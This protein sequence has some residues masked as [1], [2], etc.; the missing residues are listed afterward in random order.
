MGMYS[1]AR[2]FP[3]RCDPPE[4]DLLYLQPGSKIRAF[5]LQDCLGKGGMSSVWKATHGETK[6][7]YALKVLHG[8]L[9]DDEVVRQRF[10]E[11][12]LIQARVSHPNV[13][14]V[15]GRIEAHPVHALVMEFVDGP[16]LD[17]TAKERP[18][19]LLL[20]EIK[21][22]STGLLSALNGAHRR[23]I[24]HRDVK[25]NN[26][27]LAQEM[28]S[29]TPKLTDFGIAKF[30]Y[31]RSRT[32]TG[33]PMGTPR[34]MSPEQL[35][36]S[37]SVTLL[38]DIYSFGVTLYYMVTG[39]YPFDRDDLNALMVQIVAGEHDPASSFRTNLPPEI[40]AL[41]ESCMAKSPED[42]PQSCRQVLE[43]ILAI[44][45]NDPDESCTI[46][47]SVTGE[48]SP[49]ARP[50]SAELAAVRDR[51]A[52]I[53][54]PSGA[55]MRVPTGDRLRPSATGGV[56]P[57]SVNIPRK[58]R[59]G[60]LSSVSAPATVTRR[61]PPIPLDAVAD[62]PAWIDPADLSDIDL[63]PDDDLALSFRSSRRR[64]VVIFLLLLLLSAGAASYY[65]Y[66]VEL[67]P[68]DSGEELA[69]T[70]PTDGTTSNDEPLVSEG[71]GATAPEAVTS[72]QEVIG[73]S[74]TT[75]EE[76][77]EANTLRVDGTG[78]PDETITVASATEVGEP[79]SATSPEDTSSRRERDQE[80]ERARQADRETERQRERQRERQ[81]DEGIDREWER[82]LARRREAALNSEPVPLE[83]SLSEQA[84]A[85]LEASRP[86]TNDSSDGEGQNGTPSAT[87]NGNDSGSQAAAEP[88]ELSPL[89]VNSALRSKRS[90]FRNCFDP[91]DSS[92]ITM[93]I[94]IRPDGTVGYASAT[95]AGA[96]PAVVRCLVSVL[97]Q[98]EFDS[99]AGNPMNEQ[100]SFSRAGPR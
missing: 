47:R 37:K 83:R 67:E 33:A 16:T 20:S 52:Q 40:D 92:Q 87:S 59:T 85:A 77:V 27:I 80:R 10:V 43:R 78:G 94:N 54:Q 36:D 84:S 17:Q 44:D 93:R 72:A 48:A 79:Q 97:S 32:V 19:G 13:V 73:N 38:S 62:E 31:G 57:N 34:F 42:R 65:Y 18:L 53:Q 30:K 96:D 100:H 69:E 81:T 63:E 66:Y 35:R 88:E 82:E 95:S 12:G 24:V 86:R 3:K 99:F 11:E 29:V 64:P 39:T 28:Y 55:P 9:A 22:I 46:R 2:R 4:T 56:P 49:V 25:P 8:S 7:T 23:D 98:V 21:I 5:T 76:Q 26:V 70:S 71:T 6:Q 61:P 89:Q 50:A 58:A 14:A 41:I 68:R 15:K 90:D 74:A 75:A 60:P 45:W 1:Y 51:A 91:A